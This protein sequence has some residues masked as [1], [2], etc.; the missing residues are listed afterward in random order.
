M[1]ELRH[2]HVVVGHQLDVLRGIFAAQS[3]FEVQL[4]DHRVA[5]AFG[6]LRIKYTCESVPFSVTPPEIAKLSSTVFAPRDQAIWPG[7]VQL[8]RG[9][10]AKACVSRRMTT[11][12]D[13]LK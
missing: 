12:L 5:L 7:F 6:S 4:R 2:E 13:L 1:L 8:A 3:V 10:H 9:E 11:Q